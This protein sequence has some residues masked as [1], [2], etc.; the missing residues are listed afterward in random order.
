MDN[1]WKLV[2][3]LAGIFLAG[4]VTGAFGT[5]RFGRDWVAK[6]PGPDQWAPNHLR[7]LSE[8]LDLLPD[9]Q[10]Q[11]RP[12][13]RRNMEE[14]GR[15]RNECLV[16]TKGVFERMEREISE[17]LTPGQRLKYDQLNKEMRERVKKVVPDRNHPPGSGRTPSEG[18]RRSGPEAPA[19][20]PKKADTET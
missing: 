11:L 13:V 18:R 3:V 19:P 5:R 6:R 8:R 20:S 16:A 10:E 12:I 14:L 7:R 17:R 15:V 2:L 4:I 9:Q 1:R